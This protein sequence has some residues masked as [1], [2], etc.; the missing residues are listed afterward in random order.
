MSVARESW[1]QPATYIR[2]LTAGLPGPGQWEEGGLGPLSVSVLRRAHRSP[3]QQDVK[4]EAHT[5]PEEAS[6]EEPRLQTDI[7]VQD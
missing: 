7:L 5:S 2:V 3:G 1:L 4:C 6:E